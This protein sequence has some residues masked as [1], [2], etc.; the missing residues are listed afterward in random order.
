FALFDDGSATTFIEHTL[1]ME[2]GL[3][4]KHRP[5]C[6]SWTGDMTRKEADSL[7]VDLQI[8]GA[9]EG[10]TVY[11]LPKVHTVRSLSLPAQ[12][13]S[14][15][16]LARRYDHLG[17]IP[18]IS[19]DNAR[20]RIL[21]GLDHC[22]LFKTFRYREGRWGEPVAA[23]TR[24]G[25]TVFGPVPGLTAAQVDSHVCYLSSRTSG[26]ENLDTAL[27]E[28]F[29][30]ESLGIASPSQPLCSKEETRALHLLVSRTRL[31]E[32]RYE[33]GLIWKYDNVRLPASM[34]MALK[35]HACLKR[36]MDK[37]PELAEAI[38]RKMC[39]YESK[40]YIRRLTRDERQ[41]KTQRDWYLPIFPVSN[42]NKPG[43]I[44]IVFDAAAKSLGVSLND[45]LL[46]GPDQVATLVGVLHK[47][48]ENRV[49]IVG[50]I[51][52]M[53]FQV[54]MRKEDQRSQMFFWQGEQEADE[55]CTF[56]VAVM[57]FGA[58]CSP[59]S[60][61]FVKNTNADRFAD[62]FPRA[63]QSIK[64]EHYVDDL[65]ASV[66]TEEE[67]V[68][69]AQDVKY[70]HAQ[71]GFE[72]RNW[73]S[74]SGRVTRKLRRGTE[75]EDALNLCDDPA[76][77][78]VLGLWW[79]TRTDA[80]IF[81][82]SPRHDDSLLSGTK[83]P[84]KREVLRTLM[85]VYDPLGLIG[86]FL[87]SLKIILQD[88]WRS[89]RQWDD[90]LP[91]EL[92]KRW[93]AW[94]SGLPTLRE[95]YVPRC[96]RHITPIN[97]DVEL[98]T[99]CDAG[100]GGMAAV[101]YFRFGVGQDVEC[102]LIG[103]KTRV[104]PVKPTSVPRLELQAAVIGSRFARHILE[105]HRINIRRRIFWTDSRNV[106][107]WLKSDHR[108]YTPFV[109]F[110]IGELLDATNMNEWR[111]VPTN[112]NVA[113]EGTKWR[114]VPE[115][116]PTSRWF[117]GPSFLREAED[118]WP[119]QL[120]DLGT[121]S[122]E[123]RRNMLCHTV[124]KAE[125][126]ITFSRFSS[127]RMLLRTVGFVIRFMNNTRGRL[128]KRSV[129]RGPL[130]HEELGAAER[131]IWAQI[132][133][134]A[135]PADIKL[136]RRSAPTLHSW[137]KT[138]SKNSPLYKLTPQIDEC[139][140]LRIRGRLENCPLVQ[141]ALKKPV[142]LPR[143]HHATDLLIRDFHERYCHISQ[144]TV[145]NEIRAK[146]YIPRLRVE[147]NRVRRTCQ[148]C[149][150]WN[151]EPDSPLM[152]NIPLERVAI[153]QRPFTYCGVD[154]FGPMSV[155]VGRRVE[156]RWGVIFT[157]L[158]VRA[159]HLE[160]ASSLTTASCIMAVRRFIASRGRPT[161]FISDRGTNF[162]GAARELS[163]EFNSPDLKWAFNPPG[164]PHFG[165]CWERLVQS[166]KRSLERMQLPR[167]PTDEKLFT[168][169]KEIELIINS[170]PLTYIP[171][172]DEDAFPIT[173]NHL[174][175]GSS[176]GDKPPTSLDDSPAAIR[177]SWRSTQQGADRFWTLWV[178][179]YLPTLT[180]RT[181][182]FQPARPIKV[183]DVVIVVD[184]NAPRNCWPK[185]RVVKVT[186]A[187]DGQVRRATVKTATGVY[188][189]PA[190]KIAVIDVSHAES[191]EN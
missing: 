78:K 94:I 166:V 151:A 42:P 27:R 66:E 111:W 173:P 131:M 190:T 45:F 90:E 159:I 167:V 161:K 110:R 180:R 32:Q 109:A 182:W 97:T 62:R 120:T 34:D 108:R 20:P 69:L 64:H 30:L 24:L 115:L 142:I 140:V 170:R 70:I 187:S 136:L 28:H 73:L 92:A 87:M 54:R 41:I 133:L 119:G 179:E 36:K 12:S 99:F 156:K 19:Y 116:K 67:A 57:T 6:L 147:L 1:S 17:K 75:G 105:T 76:T 102:A 25:W 91:E 37:N 163:A 95:V 71:A 23:K 80:F 155:A 39:E 101:A 135:F 7:E 127:W 129:E 160:I 138:V 114:K 150:I 126:P 118:K 139:G 125:S 152:G 96:Y 186:R 93:L 107:C 157:C 185:G 79:D 171:L 49:A 158:T 40:G 121:T 58:T 149:R 18:A 61:H 106:I 84:T 47:F 146:F 188:E 148:L 15:D 53:F 65:L 14:V 55:P 8:S 46:P 56:V 26:D 77:E 10:A 117:R 89:G 123:L 98:H 143:Q 153:S 86:H 178:K 83:I 189:R 21:I 103:S 35:R 60:A 59:G 13:I 172:D 63:A 9:Y 85:K 29:S 100:E 38:K 3:G 165:G 5:L 162:I 33:T 72:I 2:L 164:A 137:K 191:Q 144:R 113:D 134:E 175:L 130:T 154:Y 22:H 31:L 183:G 181:K 141:P 169:L 82:L 4:G 124:A 43:K 68:A 104:A 52:E 48:R 81:R 145:M 88:A 11:H 50:D 184:N 168:T 112:E 16:D 176:N 128:Q 174:L 44:R 74:S 51:R 132:Q 177:S 122:E